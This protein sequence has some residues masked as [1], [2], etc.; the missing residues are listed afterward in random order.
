M[1]R[2]QTITKS[3][4]I[5]WSDLLP[6]IHID[7][8]RRIR[9]QSVNLIIDILLYLSRAL[10]TILWATKNILYAQNTIIALVFLLVGKR[11]IR[12]FALAFVTEHKN[13][14]VRMRFFAFRL[15][16]LALISGLAPSPV[17][18]LIL[19]YWLQTRLNFNITV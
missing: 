13:A 10:L 6:L 3:S 8:D 9:K 15:M 11:L 1:E 7:Q 18:K 16:L 17:K 14:F 4:A 5:F 12:E 19:A 2:L